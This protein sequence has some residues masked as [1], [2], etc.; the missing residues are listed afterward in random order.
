MNKC[1]LIILMS[2]TNIYNQIVSA[3]AAS[4]TK[5][6]PMANIKLR[7]SATKHSQL[8]A[9]YDDELFTIIYSR[10]IIDY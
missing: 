1:F 10:D 2:C 6:L 8:V 9:T 3:I 7:R 4:K 5:T